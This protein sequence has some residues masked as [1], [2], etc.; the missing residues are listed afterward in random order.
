MRILLCVFFSIVA[1]VG[2]VSTIWSQTFMA[3]AAQQTIHPIGDSLYFAGAEKNRKFIDVED[4]LYVKVLVVSQGDTELAILTFDCIGL[5]YPELEKIRKRVRELI[6]S[7]SVEN[8]VISS[9]HTHTGPDV[10][11]LWG[12]DHATSGV[13]PEYMKVLIE[14]SAQTVVE[15]WQRRQKAYISW[16][17]G[18]HG[19]DWVRNISEPDVIDRSVS[20]IGFRD[21]SNNHIATL[22]NFA[23]HPTILIGV[24]KGGSSDFVAGYYQ[25]LDSLQGGVNM[26][27]QGAIG[28][29]VQPEDVPRSYQNALKYGRG[30][31]IYTAE[32]LKK[33][34]K[35]T[36]DKVEFKSSRVSLAVKN[37]GFRMLSQAGVIPRPF[38]DSVTTE[39]ACFSIGD[40]LFATHPGETSPAL[41]L[42]TKSLMKNKGPKFILGLGMDALGYILK[43]VYF[44]PKNSIPHST[45]L[46]SMSVGPDTYPEVEK[47]LQKLLVE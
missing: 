1:I 19:D 17:E 41:S 42:S 15:A 29:W 22:T 43:P 37:Q 34:K 35:S 28:G 38:A 25:Y 21:S 26:Y 33:S 10:V 27:L 47:V 23:C 39:I 12:K 45:Y 31:G 5:M 6:P 2:G 20:V 32:L 7:F 3:G 4:G 24:T 9:T 16:V 14:K 30:L 46:T 40:A 36:S 11:G 13:N 18:S 44:V 8:M